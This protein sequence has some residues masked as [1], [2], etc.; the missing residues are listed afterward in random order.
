M[1]DTRQMS[2]LDAI[3]SRRS[4]PQFQPTSVSV[5]EL[6]LGKAQKAGAG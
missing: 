5:W 1:Q 6:S 4:I 3:V 2:V